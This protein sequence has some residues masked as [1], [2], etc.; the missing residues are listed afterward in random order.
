MPDTR[1]VRGEPRRDFER[2][3]KP[4]QK[5]TCQW[6]GGEGYHWVEYKVGKWA[7]YKGT[8]RHICRPPP[9]DDFK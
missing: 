7:L 3:W 9:A 5:V 1:H 6:C 4:R 2:E 8:V